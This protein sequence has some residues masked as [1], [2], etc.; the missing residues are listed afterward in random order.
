MVWRE[1]KSRFSSAFGLDAKPLLDD[2]DRHLIYLL[3]RLKSIRKGR[4][5]KAEGFVARVL[6]KRHLRPG[7]RVYAWHDREFYGD[8]VNMDEDRGLFD[9]MQ[10]VYE[11]YGINGLKE[12]FSEDDI[13]EFLDHIGMENED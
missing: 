5:K 8:E 2:H 7:R 12:S 10:E 1:Y 3:R 4:P 6:S 13:E 11:C 9:H